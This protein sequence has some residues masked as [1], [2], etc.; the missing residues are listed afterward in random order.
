M[1]IPITTIAKGDGSGIVRPGRTIVRDPA[2]WHALWAAHAGPAV[3]A[4]DVDF[5]RDKVVADFAGE[6]PSAGYEIAIADVRDGSAPLTVV[7][8][9]NAPRRGTVAAQVMVSPFHIVR[10][11]RREGEVRFVDAMA[12][13]GTGPEIASAASD[14][15]WR[16]RPLSAQAPSSTGLDPNLAAALAYL[17]GP[18][19]GVLILIVERA[20]GYVRF[21]AWQSILALGGLGVLS[22]AALFLSFATLLVSPLL[23]T[24][25]YRLSEILAIAWLVAWIVLLVK[26]FS[27]ARWEMP[28]A[29]R[30]AAR[31]A[32]RGTATS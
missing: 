29:G 24:V 7:V 26:A 22:A 3:Q 30:Y 18:F 21:H 2:E 8:N 10:L 28:I 1:S 15:E 17:A 25:M 9:E 16:G 19:S 4:P 14:A 6:R 27:G 23:F 31:L 11:P 12:D 20:N 32:A 5:A 13:P